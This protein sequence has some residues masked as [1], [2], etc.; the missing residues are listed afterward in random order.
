MYFDFFNYTFSAIVSLVTA[1]FGLSY[2]LLIESIQKI[3]GKYRSILLK[4]RFEGSE[5]YR[6][7]IFLL[8][9]SVFIAAFMPFILVA[10]IK[11]IALGYLLITIQVALLLLLIV[12]TI[13]LVEQIQLYNDPERLLNNILSNATKSDVSVVLDIMYYS[14]RMF[15]DVYRQGMS[16]ILKMITQENLN[17]GKN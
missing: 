5:I 15:P 16:W 10:F 7:Y 14:S 11:Y 6:N 3:D 8:K 2:P 9:I 17:Y 13:R 1:V 4:R 12:M